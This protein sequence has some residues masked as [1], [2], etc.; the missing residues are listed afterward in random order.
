MGL[1][2]MCIWGP[3]PENRPVKNLPCPQA[4]TPCGQIFLAWGG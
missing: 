2:W 1:G 4:H 3:I